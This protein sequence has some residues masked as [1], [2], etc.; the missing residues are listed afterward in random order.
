MDDEDIIWAVIAPMWDDLQLDEDDDYEMMAA[1]TPGQRGFIAVDWFGK[2]VCNGG[3]DQFFINSTGVLAHEAYEGF[4]ML[5]AKRYVELL[6]KVFALF[7]DGRIPK[8]REERQAAVRAIAED[9]RKHAF[10]EFDQTF[11][12][13]I[14][15]DSIV[16]YGMRYLEAHPQEFFSDV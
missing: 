16:S 14:D 2:E 12:K 4:R 9:V 10:G 1:I 15:E 7:P 6:E 11:Y 5:E 8:N 13:L 3:I